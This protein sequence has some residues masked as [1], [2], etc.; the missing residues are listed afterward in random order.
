MKARHADKPI[1]FP[2][3]SRFDQFFELAEDWSAPK[4]GGN[5]AKITGYLYRRDGSLR[6]K[7]HDEIL[8]DVQ[9]NMLGI[10][11]DS[12][13]FEIVD[14][15]DNGCSLVI[16]KYNQILGSRYL[17]YIQTDTIPRLTQ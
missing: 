4:A 10:D 14:H 5:Q 6:V 17:G 1:H 15:P 7:P 11:Y 8:A 2:T 13:Y 3:Y 16:A 12:I 9:E